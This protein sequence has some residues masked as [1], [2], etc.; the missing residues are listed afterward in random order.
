M[1]TDEFWQ[2]I[3]AAHSGS[4]GGMDRKSELLRDRHSALEPQDL[5]DFIAHFDTA[6]A[7][8][9]TWPLWGAAYV[10][11]GGCSDD[12]FS[13]FRATLIS[14]GRVTYERALSDPES[15]SEHDFDDEEDICYEG[16]QYVKN[17]VA[18]EMLGEIPKR[19]VSYPDA[20]TG[21]EWDEDTVDQLYPKLSAKYSGGMGGLEPP[22]TNKP[23]WKFW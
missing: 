9:Y 10:M 13:D 23:W 8:A 14:L 16:F 7:A 12:S 18:E 11:H 19:T 21:E 1:N 20:P 2:I 5:K 15:L 17:D 4:G 22:S 3:D 6:D